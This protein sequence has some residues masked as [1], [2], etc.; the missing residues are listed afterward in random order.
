MPSLT[1][2][3]E[4]ILARP[5]E[6]EWRPPKQPSP[7][8]SGQSQEMDL[9]TLEARLGFHV[10]TPQHPVINNVLTGLLPGELTTYFGD[11]S[12]GAQ[13]VYSYESE[14]HVFQIVQRRVL[15]SNH[16]LMFIY[17]DSVS[18]WQTTINDGAATV[19]IPSFDGAYR[20]VVW[21]SGEAFVWITFF[22]PALEDTMMEIVE[23]LV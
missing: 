9:P 21:V 10:L 4:M 6:V 1:P 7:P 16:P 11:F 2:T 14:D 13:T 5:G 12:A 8:P 22:W 18:A 20:F 17:G 15:R 3:V 23:S 19:V